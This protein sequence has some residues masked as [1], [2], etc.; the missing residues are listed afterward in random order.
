[1][2][3]ERPKAPQLSPKEIEHLETLKSVVKQSLE[4]GKF[5]SDEIAH[6]K[7]LLAADKQITYEGLRT[8][9]ETI[10][11]VMGEVLPELDWQS[12]QE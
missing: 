3:V 8:I 12:S 4:D 6:I 1:M 2:K 5:S 7:S 10:M 9:H 11:S